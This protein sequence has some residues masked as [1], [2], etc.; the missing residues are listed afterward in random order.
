MRPKSG[1]KN[2]LSSSFVMIRFLFVLFLAYT[3]F[4]TPCYSLDY[5]FSQSP[6]DVTEIPD[7]DYPDALFFKGPTLF[8]ILTLVSSIN[9][10]IFFVLEIR[11]FSRDQ[12]VNK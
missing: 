3:G 1:G 11:L 2:I 8:E 7:I 12:F 10:F 4:S 9:N 6:E 5:D